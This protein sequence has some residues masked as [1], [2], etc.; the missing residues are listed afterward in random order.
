MSGLRV[1]MVGST[2][3]VGKELVEILHERSFPVGELRLLASKRSAGKKM[4]TPFGGVVV[5]E[6]CEKNLSGLDL[7]FFSAGGGVSQRLAP[8]AVKAGA[9]VIDNSSAFRMDPDVPLVI[10]EVNGADANRHNGI[11]ANPNCTTIIVLVVLKPMHDALGIER[12]VVSTYQAASGAGAKGIDA[13]MRESATVLDG[14]GAEPSVFPYAAASKHHALAF[15][16]IPHV[17][18]FDE[19]GYTKEEWKMV[20]ESRKI[21]SLPELRISVTNVR[22]PV[23]RCHAAT[24][25]VEVRKDVDERLVKGVL[26]EAPGLE[27]VDDPKNFEYP[28]P[29]NSSGRDEVSVG[30]VRRDPSMQRGWNLWVVGD[31]IRKGAALNAVQIAEYLYCSPFSARVLDG[32]KEAS[33]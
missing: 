30:R 26:A 29:V 22:V 13:L 28:M 25:N 24:L 14:R 4:E 9:I 21:L 11:V 27:L 15:N 20:N 5:E 7:V 12:V 10:P 16:L 17:D 3:A 33:C 6:A 23:F 31:Q 19:A 8:V 2:G 18:V 32:G 1:A